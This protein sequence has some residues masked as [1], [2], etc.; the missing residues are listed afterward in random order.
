L[1]GNSILGGCF[2]GSDGLVAGLAG[3]SQT[4]ACEVAN[5]LDVEGSTLVEL[6]EVDV[7]EGK[8][9]AA[10]VLTELDGGAAARAKVK[11]SL[12]LVKGNTAA[13]EGS[14]SALQAVGAKAVGLLSVALGG[15]AVEGTRVGSVGAGVLLDG[16]RALDGGAGVEEGGTV[17][18]EGA[19][20]TGGALNR[21]RG[22]TESAAESLDV[23]GSRG[24]VSV[25]AS[26]VGRGGGTG[27]RGGAC[28]S[29][30]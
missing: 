15:A 7:A 1:R 28:F 17:H 22:P 26:I 3:A 13:A 8:P 25:G 24:G 12:A 27:T 4:V 29:I 23:D 5:D 30:C 19:V 11:S 10:K 6:L 16:A 14:A 18:L 21:W 9:G 2:A 20:S